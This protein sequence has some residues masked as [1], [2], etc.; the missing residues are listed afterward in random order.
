MVFV[1]LSSRLSASVL[2]AIVSA[3]PATDRVAVSS[4]DIPL[5]LVSV[6]N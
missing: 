1:S 4:E 3:V 5:L 2:V 6:L